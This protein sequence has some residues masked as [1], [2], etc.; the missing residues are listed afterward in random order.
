MKKLILPLALV[1]TMSSCAG[2][3]D[4]VSSDQGQ[5]VVSTGA[6]TLGGI[7]GGPPGAAIGG[8]IAAALL[9]AFGAKKK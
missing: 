5:A 1:F 2:L 8:A 4:F 7:V 3:G 6:K 9:A